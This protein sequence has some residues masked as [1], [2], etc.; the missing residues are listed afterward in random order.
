VHEFTHAVVRRVA[1]LDDEFASPVARGLN[2]GY[3]D[4]AQATL[5]D[6]PRFGDW[7]RNL[8][9]GARRCDD[10][11]LRL[12]ARPTHSLSD[13]YAVG[14]AWASLLWDFRG[15]VGPGIA[16]A[17]AFHSLHFLEPRCTYDHARQALHHADRALFPAR[18]A[19]RHRAEIDGV[20]EARL[21][22]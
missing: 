4:Y 5:Y 21:A 2:E 16:D 19:G 11:G 17:V 22:R 10:P 14:A 9:E 3:A 7:V 18:R 15:R 12:M 8:P 1:R 20:F 6:D 13:R